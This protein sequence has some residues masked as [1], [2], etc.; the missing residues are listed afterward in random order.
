VERV[1]RGSD[2]VHFLGSISASA[3]DGTDHTF[4]GNVTLTNVNSHGDTVL[5]IEADSNNNDGTFESGV[6]EN[7]NPYIHLKQDGGGV[8]GMIG[9]SG[10]Q[11]QWPDGSTLSGSLANGM[12]IGMTGDATNQNRALTLAAGNSASLQIKNNADVHILKGDLFVDVMTETTTHND[13]IMTVV[14]DS[15]SGQLMYT[16]S[17]GGGGSVDSFNGG[18]IDNALFIEQYIYHTQTATE[19]AYFGFSDE[20]QF[21]VGLN[22]TEKL[23]L[24]SNGELH[25][26]DDIIAF[27]T[28]PSDQRLKTNIQ[29]L[30][31][32]L[33]TICNLEGVRYDWK[34]RNT[35]TQLGVIA[36][37]VER[38]VPEIVKEMELP[39]HAPDDNKYKTVKYEQLVPHLI[40]AI[41]ELRSELNEVKRQLKE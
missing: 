15:G 17:Y 29:L 24:R 37:Q 33:D 31:G 19:A 8:D 20:D 28:T 41:K 25:I 39:L 9:L 35:G 38:H 1:Q 18:A 40:E 23:R 10:E 2:N 12:V 36:Q 30:T 34:H 27:S 21:S 11:H 14:Y 26:T 32:S 22:G 16:G 6:S 5:T 7:S 4:G 3:D 13:A